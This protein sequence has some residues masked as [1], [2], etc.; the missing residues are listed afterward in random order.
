MTAKEIEDKIK[1]FLPFKI[2]AISYEKRIGFLS[3]DNP[4]YNVSES[5]YYIN[6]WK[7]KI[8]NKKSFEKFKRQF[9]NPNDGTSLIQEI[10]IENSKVFEANDKRV[11]Y[12]LTREEK[13]DVNILDFWKGEGWK[14]YQ[15]SPNSFG[16][17]VDSK[18][19][20]IQFNH[21]Q[22][23]KDDNDGN[24]VEFCYL[25]K[26]KGYL[27]AEN[28]YFTFELS[29]DNKVINVN[30]ETT[31][32]EGLP[33]AFHISDRKLSRDK[34]IRVNV[35]SKHYNSIAEYVY[36][37]VLDLMN[38]SYAYANTIEK[39]RN[40]DACTY[41][42]GVANEVCDNGYLKAI[43]SG[44]Y[45]YLR[46]SNEKKPCPDCNQEVAVG[47]VIDIAY[48]ARLSGGND[49]TSAITFVS[50]DVKAL[51]FTK[52]DITDTRQRIFG[53]GTGKD[54]KTDSTKNF[55]SELS[56]L[57][58]GE[59]QKDV[60]DQIKYDLIGNIQRSAAFV[61]QSAFGSSYSSVL[62]DLGSNYMLYT[63]E[64]LLEKRKQAEEQG[65]SDVLKLDS[66]IMEVQSKG[67]ESEKRKA[68]V[69]LQLN[70]ILGK[71]LAKKAIA[72]YEL[73]VMPIEAIDKDVNTIIKDIIK[74]KS[75]LLTQNKEEEDEQTEI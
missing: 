40:V 36:S 55:N 68:K 30:P 53:I 64:Q 29:D 21:V 46:G 14:L 51:E 60:L 66:Q 26:K 37:I 42:N 24:V 25:D 45:L 74:H 75:E 34:N 2:E 7:E 6:R 35:L 50:P 63:V 65:L 15:E 33:P 17:V 47:G 57:Y 72:I 19:L 67:V 52:A 48:Q 12:T 41:N 39:L 62:V 20:A 10:W 16:L 18:I 32:F 9:S 49:P 38:K 43:D 73:E 1:D 31:F 8:N 11:N 28:Q 54:K 70:T 5:D 69:I 59:S 56:I 71:D 27:F 13:K 4:F 61:G 58:A 44:E 23:Y 22:F 3:V